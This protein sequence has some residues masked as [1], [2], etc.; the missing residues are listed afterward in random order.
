METETET[1]VRAGTR[2]TTNA[3]DKLS[4]WVHDESSV[5]GARVVAIVSHD[6]LQALVQAAYDEHGML[7][8]PSWTT[9]AA[10]AEAPARRYCQCGQAGCSDPDPALVSF[11]DRWG[12]TMRGRA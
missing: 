4:V 6:E 3:P 1:K 9:E 2:P 12:Q 8:S 7:A 11:A 5:T 10:L